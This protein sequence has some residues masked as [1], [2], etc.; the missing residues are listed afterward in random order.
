MRLHEL[1]LNLLVYLDAL[2][3]ERNVSKAAER[4]SLTQSAMSLALARLREHFHDPIL[5]QVGKTMVPTSLAL[6]LVEPVRNVLIQIRAIAAS[7]DTFDP[8]SSKRKIVIAG[9]DFTVDVVLK[10][11]L[12]RLSELAPHMRIHNRAL[13]TRVR[14]D[15]KQGMVDFLFIPEVY[16]LEDHPRDLLFTAS[17]TC[18][19]WSRNTLVGDKLT[20]DQYKQLGH[21][22][23]KLGDETMPT[24]EQ[25]FMKRYGD[26]RRIEV[27]VPSFALAVQLVTGTQRIVTC[28]LQHAHMYARQC[29]L[30]LV[31]PPFRIP[32]SRLHLQWHKYMHGDPAL[33]WV[34]QLMK[35]TLAEDLQ[36]TAGRRS[37]G[38]G[39]SNGNP[40]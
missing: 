1:N 29:S 38:A 6:S 8:A 31:T 34:R 15:F 2:L 36:Q 25:W 13:T 18:A 9:S 16:L 7:T 4:V 28:H 10:K 33:A 19:V 40:A 11:L 14:E 32:P 24:Y 12:P 30:R 21:I 37:T 17:F 35:A 26:V 27:E 3:A 20:F 5:R 23:V 22:A 39:A